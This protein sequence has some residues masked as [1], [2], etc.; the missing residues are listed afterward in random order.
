LTM[1]SSAVVG[2]RGS[3]KGRCPCGNAC[4]SSGPRSRVTAT[5]IRRP[6]SLR[7]REFA[8]VI[9]V[10]RDRRDVWWATPS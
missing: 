8:R 6:A 10:R 7:W 2:W 4:V 9:M 5:L 3:R 1:P